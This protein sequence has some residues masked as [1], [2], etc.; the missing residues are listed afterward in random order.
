M[1]MRRRGDVAWGE[2][3][4]NLL[5]LG[6]APLPALLL[7]GLAIWPGLYNSAQLLPWP[8]PSPAAATFWP[9]TEEDDLSAW[10]DDLP[11][12]E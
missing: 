7:L 9:E 2:R 12:P 4:V 10:A 5:A 8:S 3:G 6:L 11:C 1:R